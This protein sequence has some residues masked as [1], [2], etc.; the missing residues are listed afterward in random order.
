MALLQNTIECKKGHW[1]FVPIF[2]GSSK[3]SIP[4]TINILENLFMAW[5]LADLLIDQVKLKT[6]NNSS[7]LHFN[8]ESSIK[9]RIYFHPKNI[10]SE[11]NN[12]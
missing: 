8:P 3:L 4:S 5:F 9:F 6:L 1:P 2:S 11:R 12:P 7:I 10:K